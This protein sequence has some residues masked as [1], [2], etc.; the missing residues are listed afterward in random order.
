[1]IKKSSLYV[2]ILVQLILIILYAKL[3]DHQLISINIPFHKLSGNVTA[4]E[5]EGWYIDETFSNIEDE[6]FCSSGEIAL[7]KG[8]YNITINYETNKEHNYSTA[9][10]ASARMYKLFADE[11]RMQRSKQYVTY[12]IYLLEDVTD[13]EIRNYYCGEGYFIVR[14]ILVNETVEYLRMKLFV[15]FL[16]FLLVDFLWIMHR[17]AAFQKVSKQQYIVVMIIVAISVFVSVHIFD[18]FLFNTQDLAFHLLRIEGLKEGLRSRQIPVKMQPNWLEGYG[19]PVSVYYGDLFLYIPAILRIIGF[20]LQ[21]SY[22]VFIF[23]INLATSGIAFWCCFKISRD[24]AVSVVSMCLYVLNPYRLTDIY[25]RNAIGETLALTFLPLVI[26]GMF[27]VFASDCFEKSYKK[28]WIPLV[29]GFTG[30]IESHILTCVICSIFVIMD[31]IMHWKKIFEK[32]RFIVLAKTVIFTSLLNAGFIF[33]CITSMNGI[34]ITASKR[35]TARIQDGGVLFSELF[36]T[37]ND[38]S[39]MILSVGPAVGMVLFLYVLLYSFY[40]K[41]TM[42]GNQLKRGIY[43]FGGGYYHYAWLLCISRGIGY[44]IC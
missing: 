6:V 31:C 13:F 41:D 28:S 16:L 27:N 5:R 14:D 35:I 11:V 10:A 34:A 17:K 32:A 42:I 2:V 25:E 7:R 24:R 12:T 21:F 1:M 20:P 3:N 22:G 26:Y 29:I 33:P 9:T 15:M 39:K 38:G 19:Y 36:R 43:A 4:G 18:G 44:L 30:I 8:T 40:R 23:M 37:Y